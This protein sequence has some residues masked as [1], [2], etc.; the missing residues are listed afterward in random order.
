MFRFKLLV[1]ISLVILSCNN[2]GKKKDSF[3]DTSAIHVDSIISPLD[4]DDPIRDSTLFAD[5]KIILS[6]LKD[7]NYDSLL[8][9]IH[10][11][12]GIRFS[13]YGFIST[14][15]DVVVTTNAM[16]HWMDKKR[17]PRLVWGSFDGNE[18]PINMTPDEYINRFVYDVNFLEADTIKVNKFMGNGNSLNNLTEI[19]P[20]CSFVENYYL[21][22]SK[23]NQE[24]DWRSLRLV[25]KFKDGK[26]Y[27]VGIVH[28]EW[29]I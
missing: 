16:L 14:K 8:K 12:V 11:E 19:Y 20:G 5:T 4:V 26:Y 21:G 24:Y 13:P 15:N 2:S 23:K 6:V 27:L 7:K 3:S 29:T 28:D 25:F 9:F 18:K 1:C 17:Q 22:N 10:P